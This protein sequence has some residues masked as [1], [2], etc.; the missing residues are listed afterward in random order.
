MLSLTEKQKLTFANE[1]SE[2]FFILFFN[3]SS[4]QK[5]YSHDTISIY[6]NSKNSWFNFIGSLTNELKFDLSFQLENNSYNMPSISISIIED[7]IDLISLAKILAINF[8]EF[9][10]YFITNELSIDEALPLMKGIIGIDQI[11][12]INDPHDPSLLVSCNFFI[13]LFFSSL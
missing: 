13:R 11:D 3:I 10:L 2:K 7:R 12:I 9:E 8:S 6:D 5:N 1:Y 4:I